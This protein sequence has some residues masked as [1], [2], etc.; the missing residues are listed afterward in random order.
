MRE[1]PIEKTNGGMG[2]RVGGV[3]CGDTRH[4]REH[5]LE[6]GDDLQYSIKGVERG[7]EL[8]LTASFLSSMPSFKLA[9]AARKLSAASLGL[10]EDGL[11]CG[12]EASI[13]DSRSLLEV[14]HR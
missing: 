10:G 7:A 12:S 6:L 14:V 2:E 4:E 3:P 11:S 8:V 5:V 1:V 13:C 9:W